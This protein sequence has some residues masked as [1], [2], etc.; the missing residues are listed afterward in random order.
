MLEAKAYTVLLPSL[1][2]DDYRSEDET[3]SYQKFY[4]EVGL[5][6]GKNIINELITQNP[7]ADITLIGFS[8]GAT[9]AWL[10]SEDIRLQRIIGVY[11]SQ[12]RNY[13]QV[14]PKVKTTL[15]FTNEES[16]DIEQVIQ[17]LKGKKQLSVIQIEGKH[18]F[19]HHRNQNKALADR[20]EQNIFCLFKD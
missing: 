3:L 2:N 9:I 6:K 17:S 18:G 19:Y 1:Y 16:F 13:I 12:I 20:L 10:F 7:N 5:D 14:E 11:G 4:A 8:V 15:F